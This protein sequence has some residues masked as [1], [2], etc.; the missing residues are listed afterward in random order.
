MKIQRFNVQS[1]AISGECERRALEEFEGERVRLSRKNSVEVQSSVKGFYLP[2]LKVSA[3]LMP[4]FGVGPAVT[5]NNYLFLGLTDGEVY[6]MHPPG[7]GGAVLSS[8]RGGDFKWPPLGKF[9]LLSMEKFSPNAM[10]M[11]GYLSKVG[12]VK[13]EGLD[14]ASRK[15]AEELA[16]QGYARIYIPGEDEP[17][18]KSI[19]TGLLD[20]VF[21]VHRSAYYVKSLFRL[22]QPQDGAYNISDRLV[23]TEVFEGDYGL[24]RVNNTPD[25]LMYIASLVYNARLIA[26]GIIYLP[27]MECVYLYL[28][29]EEYK[30]RIVGALKGVHAAKKYSHP[31]KPEPLMIGTNGQGVNSTPMESGAIKFVNVAGMEG[32]K[33]EL[34]RAIVYPLARPDLSGQYSHKAGGGIL[35]YGPPGCGKTYI[36]RATVGEAGV[37]LFTADVQDVIGQNPEAGSQRLHE[38]FVEARSNAPSILFFDELDA[39]GGSRTMQSHAS[40]FVVNQLLSEMSGVEES[41]TNVL[42]VG[43]TNAPWDV[44]P[45][46]RRA[47]RFTTKV[48]IPPPDFKSRVDMFRMYA[49]RAPIADDVDYN[50]L[51]ELTEYFSSSD[52]AA[53]CDKAAEIPWSES[54]KGMPKRKLLMSD[55]ISVLSGWMSS[56]P[57]WFA[58]AGRELGRSGEM[59]LYPELRRLLEDYNKR[60]AGAV[61]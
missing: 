46:L 8:L 20:S 19:A 11:F 1:Y 4:W 41:N 57:A 15:A 42:I 7:V 49:R 22:P 14:G 6:Y 23:E 36:M 16:T 12:S 59:D 32:V 53:V 43:A 33:E 13:Y 10:S 17:M 40:R 5:Q 39:L 52:I 21:S 58:L 61:T 48:F 24:L 28:G 56:L 50:K 30:M 25:K 26:R 44:D 29:K 55:F 34:N 54:M 35:L 47:G 18:L 31:Y 38:V 60:K 2:L 9:S 37:N 45:A 3:Q 27:V 51:A